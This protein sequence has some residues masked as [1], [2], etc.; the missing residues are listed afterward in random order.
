MRERGGGGWSRRMGGERE[1]G[2]GCLKAEGK[3]LKKGPKGGQGGRVRR[4]EREGR[5]EGEWKG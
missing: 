4:R 2:R 5:R 3:G 1:E